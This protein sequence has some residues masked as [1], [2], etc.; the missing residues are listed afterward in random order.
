MWGIPGR[1]EQEAVSA[2]RSA[3][4]V[5][6]VLGLSARIEGEEMKVQAEGSP[7]ATERHSICRRR[8]ND[9]WKPSAL[10]VNRSCWC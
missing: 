10:R 7:V 3:D 1:E 2:A 6:M 5:V 8:K 9:C 4:L